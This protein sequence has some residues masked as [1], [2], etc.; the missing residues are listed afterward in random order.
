MPAAL[1]ISNTKPCAQDDDLASV[2][3]RAFQLSSLAE[4]WRDELHT[5]LMAP[6]TPRTR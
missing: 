5:V 3:R 4:T 2:L 6:P 1:T